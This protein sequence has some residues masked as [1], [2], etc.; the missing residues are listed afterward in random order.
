[1][2]LD[3]QALP[4][5]EMNWIQPKGGLAVYVKKKVAGIKKDQR[6]KVLSLPLVLR[7]S[8]GYDSERWSRRMV[9]PIAP[10][11]CGRAVWD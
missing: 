9:A 8:G 2:A 7:L 11:L 1:L 5:G 4:T 10:L 6:I 3:L